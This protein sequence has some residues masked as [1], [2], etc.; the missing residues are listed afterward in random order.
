MAGVA[1]VVV[2]DDDLRVTSAKAGYL[3]V[4]ATPLVLD[5]TDAVGHRPPGSCDWAA[6]AAYAEAHVEPEAD[7][8]AGSAYR[9]H[10]VGVLTE[11]VL[12]TAAD[13]ARRGIS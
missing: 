10:L 4:A 12:R 6:A 13:T 3:S 2:L 9:R 7:I 5:L 11:R 1:A 8:H